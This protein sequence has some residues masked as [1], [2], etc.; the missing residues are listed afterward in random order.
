MMAKYKEPAACSLLRIC[1]NAFADWHWEIFRLFTATGQLEVLKGGENLSISDVYHAGAEC[2]LTV[3]LP[4]SGA[5]GW[6]CENRPGYQG[7]DSRP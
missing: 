7:Y 3:L 5:A 4:P 1:T 6:Q 2:R